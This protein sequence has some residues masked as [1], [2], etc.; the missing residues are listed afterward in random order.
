MYIGWTKSLVNVNFL[1]FFINTKNVLF[2]YFGGHV[3]SGTKLKLCVF[4]GNKLIYHSQYLSAYF[5]PIINLRIWQR[6][7][8]NWCFE[9]WLNQR[10]LYSE[11]SE[12]LK[13]ASSYIKIF[14]S[15]VSLQISFRL[16]KG[17]AVFFDPKQLLWISGILLCYFSK[18]YSIKLFKNYNTLRHW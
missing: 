8:T 14:F 17:C 6:S 2:H 13:K 3:F 4:L 10:W 11:N 5:S 15:N 7:T 18:W 12:I 1:K 9:I 16:K